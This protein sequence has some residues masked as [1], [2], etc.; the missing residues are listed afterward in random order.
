VKCP[1][2]GCPAAG[3]TILA[4]NTGATNNV[5]VDATH[6]YWLGSNGALFRIAK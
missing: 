1:L 6:V 2:T 3:P 4:T 5:A